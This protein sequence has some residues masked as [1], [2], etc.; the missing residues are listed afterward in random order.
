MKHIGYGMYPL[1]EKSCNCFS[2]LYRT[3]TDEQYEEILQLIIN[4]PRREWYKEELSEEDFDGLRSRSVW[5]RLQK[6][7]Q[8]GGVLNEEATRI[9]ADIEKSNQ[10]WKLSH[11]DRDEFPFWTGRGDE[12]KSIVSAPREKLVLIEWLK[13][14]PV[15]HFWAEDDWSTLCRDDFELTSS[16]LK[17][18]AS[19]GMWLS[20][21]WRQGIQVWSETEELDLAQQIDLFKFVLKAPDEKLVE[22]AWSLSRWLKKLQSR[23]TITDNHFL[24]FYDRLLS[25]PY[26]ID[27]DV[28]TIN[29]AINHPVGMLVESLFSWWFAKNRM[30]MKAWMKSFKVDWK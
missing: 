10:K 3:A 12:P 22:M 18:T 14:E 29:T 9:V 26:E 23:G 20:E 28:A 30:M 15:D 16:A 19:S 5:L 11:D 24:H 1:I 17:E 4:G 27:K 25:L 21:R 7:K 13:E 2:T 8:D 6:L